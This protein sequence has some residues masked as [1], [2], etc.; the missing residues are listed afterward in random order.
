MIETR[1]FW[2]LPLVLSGACAS[3]SGEAKVMP[4]FARAETTEEPVLYARDGS[5]V[6]IAGVARPDPA[7]PIHGAE[8]RGESRMQMLDLYQRVVGEKDAMAKELRELDRIVAETRTARE[9]LER[10][11]AEQRARITA[12]QEEL[13]K[14]D[15]DRND[16]AARLTTAQIRRLEAEKLL[17]E[18]RLA[19]ARAGEREAWRTSQATPASARESAVGSNPERSELDAHRVGEAAMPGSRP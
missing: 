2:W 15:Q 4:V 8:P 11:S 1:A 18:T 16:L 5:I 6:P 17:L 9:A 13:A 3:T 12:L 7:A 14:A 19:L 10:D